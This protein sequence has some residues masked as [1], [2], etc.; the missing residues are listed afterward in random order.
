MAA[1]CR[2]C[3]EAG[4]LRLVPDNGDALRCSPAARRAAAR[5]PKVYEHAACLEAAEA[6]R[7]AELAARRALADECKALRA[8]GRDDEAL[9]L[10]DAFY[11]V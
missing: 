9:A 6:K 7:D 8:A 4:G 11:D 3:G 5:M 1:S 10:F 2:F